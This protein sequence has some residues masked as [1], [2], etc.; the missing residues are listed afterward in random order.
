MKPRKFK[1]SCYIPEDST[2]HNHLYENPKFYNTVSCLVYSLS[3][4]RTHNKTDT[5]SIN[6]KYYEGE[7]MAQFIY[8][9]YEGSSS[10]ASFFQTL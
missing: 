4:V 10:Y 2:L 5:S 6:D 7:Y 9:I 1:L 3:Q 8:A